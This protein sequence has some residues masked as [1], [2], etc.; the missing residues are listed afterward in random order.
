MPHDEDVLLPFELHNHWLESDHDV[1]IRF[2]PCIA[3]I[4]LSD[5]WP[6]FDTEVR[7]VPRYR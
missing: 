5:I 7:H 6:I 4:I 2:A 1:S 3:I